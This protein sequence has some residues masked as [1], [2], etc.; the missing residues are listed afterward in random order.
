M[1]FIPYI[2]STQSLRRKMSLMIMGAEKCGRHTRFSAHFSWQR[3]RSALADFFIGR[4][5]ERYSIRTSRLCKVWKNAEKTIYPAEKSAAFQSEQV[6]PS[7][8]A[9]LESLSTKTDTML[10]RQKDLQKQIDVPLATQESHFQ[11][12]EH[13]DKAVKGLLDTI[14]ITRNALVEK[15]EKVVAASHAT[16]AAAF[17]ALETLGIFGVVAGGCNHLYFL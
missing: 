1:S 15:T 4:D 7:Q 11:A 5:R 13:L 6:V 14:E 16:Y 10:E 9:S 8:P 17:R 3:E 2:M 12:V